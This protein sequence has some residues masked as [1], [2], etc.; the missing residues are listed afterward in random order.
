MQLNKVHEQQSNECMTS[1]LTRKRAEDHQM[2]RV[3]EIKVKNH[4]KNSIVKKIVSNGLSNKL[5]LMKIDLQNVK[6]N[7][8]LSKSSKRSINNENK[9][10]KSAISSKLLLQM[11]D[12]NNNKTIST[13]QIKLKSDKSNESGNTLSN[14]QF[15]LRIKSLKSNL[16]GNAPQDTLLGD[17][18][19]KTISPKVM[20]NQTMMNINTQNLPVG[21]NGTLYTSNY[22]HNGIG[23]QRPKTMTHNRRDKYRVN[24]DNTLLNKF[25]KLPIHKHQIINNQLNPYAL[26]NIEGN[27]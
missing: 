20:M 18:S 10:N 8:L 14:T 26:K 5:D 4:V 1:F 19:A 11:E 17:N 7:V 24:V 23:I 9:S 13:D 12:I 21:N 22:N 15:Q 3:Q 25:S 16:S 27:R 6:K 2:H